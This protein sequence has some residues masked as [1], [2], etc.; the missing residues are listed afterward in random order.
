MGQTPRIFLVQSEPRGQVILDANLFELKSRLC[1]EN[2]HYEHAMVFAK[3]AVYILQRAWARLERYQNSSQLGRN[4]EAPSNTESI[5]QE[6]EKLSLGN[7]PREGGSDKANQLFGADFWPLIRPLLRGLSW[8]IDIA[9][10]SGDVQEAQYLSRQA[11]K[12][13][14][15]ARS[16]LVLANVL[17]G[18]GDT[19]CRSG[20]V[21]EGRMA[22]DL[23]TTK[24]SDPDQSKE[25][26]LHHRSLG[27]LHHSR[28]Q[29]AAEVESYEKGVSILQCISS[30]TFPT[31]FQDIVIRSDTASEPSAVPTKTTTIVTKHQVKQSI[32]KPKRSSEKRKN[33]MD[34]TS[35]PPLACNNS[36]TG[37]IE[38]EG[39]CNELSRLKAECSLEK[40][41]PQEVATLMKYEP[42]SKRS[43]EYH[44][45]ARHAIARQY[46]VEGLAAMTKDSV[47]GMLV[48]SAMS[49]PSVSAQYPDEDPSSREICE[50][51]VTKRKPI[52]DSPFAKALLLALKLVGESCY[53]WGQSCSMLTL[54]KS[55]SI[56]VASSLILSFS[57]QNCEAPAIHP[58][59]LAYALGKESRAVCAIAD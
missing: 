52:A 13:A 46:F 5:V 39:L 12:A 1:A 26:A 8:A 48:E 10:H 41:S 29:R 47:F 36:L 33:R 55:M 51:R 2:G 28:G 43:T 56:T 4:A 58:S 37:C 59:K 54:F 15:S 11:E 57:R 49:L 18:S 30:P 34:P 25:L 31:S 17:V 7:K 9:K 16:D 42:E 40:N 44:A 45:Q 32:S 3:K 14:T 20:D 24:Y 23:A 35:S 21:E 19:A 6:V 50:D 38:L 53:R 22:L 27:T